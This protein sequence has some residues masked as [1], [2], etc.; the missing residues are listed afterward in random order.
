[1]KWVFFLL[2]AFFQCGNKWYKVNWRTLLWQKK[3]C[4]IFLLFILRF[5]LSSRMSW[6][7]CQGH[8]ARRAVPYTAC[9]IP[10][11]SGQ[12]VSHM[13][14]FVVSSLWSSLLHNE[15]DHSRDNSPGFVGKCDIIGLLSSFCANTFFPQLP[16]VHVNCSANNETLTWCALVY[17]NNFL[18]LLRTCSW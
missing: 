3:C 13:E 12:G 4:S 14:A 8:P 16:L 10:S 7:R 18:C 1:M 9:V 15:A 17:L 5:Q 11:L 6:Y 2:T